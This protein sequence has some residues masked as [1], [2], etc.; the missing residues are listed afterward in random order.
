[1]GGAMQVSVTFRNIQATEALKSY[2]R[3]KVGRVQRHINQPVDAH[4]VLF[5]ERF[6][7]VAEIVLSANGRPLKCLARDDDMYAAIDEAIDK[8]DRQIRKYA[9]KRKD[10]RPPEVRRAKRALRAR[11]E[12]APAEPVPPAPS[13]LIADHYAEKGLTPELAVAELEARKAPVLLFK[14]TR[15]KRVSVVFRRPDGSYGLVEGK[16]RTK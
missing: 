4:V 3:E 5:R 9:E 15:T 14:N 12:V 16:A 1:M 11:A 7:N 13:I 6:L 2:A 8:L 10:H